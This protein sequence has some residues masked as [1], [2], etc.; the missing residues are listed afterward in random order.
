MTELGFADA[1]TALSTGAIDAGILI[2]PLV[3]ITAARGSIPQPV[4]AVQF[5]DTSYVGAAVTQLDP[6]RP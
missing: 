2:E 1:A 4:D 3:T 5:I 6:Y